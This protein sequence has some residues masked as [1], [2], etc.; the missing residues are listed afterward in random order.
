[1]LGDARELLA[2]P[3]LMPG[4][5][6]H[7]ESGFAAG[8]ELSTWSGMAGFGPLGLDN[9]GQGRIQLRCTSPGVPR[10]LLASCRFAAEPDCHWTLRVTHASLVNGRHPRIL[11]LR[12]TSP[13]DTAIPPIR[14]NIRPFAPS[15]ASSRSG[16]L[17]VPG[18][19][20]PVLVCTSCG[21]RS[22]FNNRGVSPE[23]MNLGAAT[24]PIYSG[25][26][27]ESGRGGLSGATQ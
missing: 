22:T 10:Y 27:R 20:S 21:S 9:T 25:P 19:M 6:L 26:F 15:V 13:A 12:G 1:V 18:R 24:A 8:A 17:I 7:H 11:T 5:E 23:F 3:I 4:A 14:P 2:K 16:L